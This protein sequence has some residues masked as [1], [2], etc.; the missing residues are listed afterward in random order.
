MPCEHAEQR[1]AE[2]RR[3]RE[4]ELDPALVP[5]PHGPGDVGQRQRRGDHD[6]GERRVREVLQQ[7]GHE[8][9]H[10]HDRRRADD[11]R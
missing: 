11:A 3:D 7:P 5:Q 10:Q 4:Q 6:R 9:E 2:E 8:H 1:D